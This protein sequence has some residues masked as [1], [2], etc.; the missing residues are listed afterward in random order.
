MFFGTDNPQAAKSPSRKSQSGT[1]RHAA[2]IIMRMPAMEDG[3]KVHALVATCPPLDP[4]SLYCNLLQC[5]HFAETCVFAERDDM[6]AGW[7][8]AYRPPREPDT[9]FIWQVAVAKEARGYGLGLQLIK[10]LLARPALTD[11]RRVR[12]TIT[13]DN[14]ASWALFRSLAR[15]LGSRFSATPWLLADAHFGGTHASEN[16]ITIGPL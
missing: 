14:R 10:T 13:A 16:L 5:T 11:I 12:T 8:S 3:S 1:A 4:N 7:L 15:H 6:P 9:L 2:P